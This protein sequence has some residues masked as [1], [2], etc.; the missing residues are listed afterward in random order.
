MNSKE[1]YSEMS[2]KCVFSDHYL[3]ALNAGW[4][5]HVSSNKKQSSCNKHQVMN[6]VGTAKE[7]RVTQLTGVHGKM[8]LWRRLLLKSPK[9]QDLN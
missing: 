6:T 2:L 7:T 9:F 1:T 8:A 3:T 5:M 4:Q